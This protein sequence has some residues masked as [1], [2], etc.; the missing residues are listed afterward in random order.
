M[1]SLTITDNEEA[2]KNLLN[3]IRILKETHV[4]VGLPSSAGGKLQ[5]ILAIQEH[6]SPVNHI[7]PR[8]VVE[9]G[10]SQESTKQGMIDGLTGIDEAVVAGDAAGIEAA[11]ERAGQA[12]A[13]GI[14]N[15]I[16]AGISPPNA[17][18]TVNG[19]WIRN[20]ASGKPV[21][22]PGK[23]FNKPLFNTGA[24]YN[25]FSFEVKKG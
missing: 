8:P 11:F 3:G 6:G 15:Y 7:P 1:L 19:G 14:R 23:G 20:F 25:A 18:L 21:H 10:L 4:E 24:L 9:P 5:M 17:A 16:D 22:I 12:G 2:Q 13:D